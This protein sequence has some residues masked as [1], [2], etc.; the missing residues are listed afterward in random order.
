MH[1]H[2]FKKQEANSYGGSIEVHT[3]QTQQL[4]HREKNISKGAEK[5]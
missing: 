2:A 5:H 3:F 4:Q 1:S